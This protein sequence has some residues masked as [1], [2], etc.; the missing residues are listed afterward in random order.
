MA[1]S[2]APLVWYLVIGALLVAAGIV[3]AL[4]SRRR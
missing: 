3:L 2:G 1:G 4:I